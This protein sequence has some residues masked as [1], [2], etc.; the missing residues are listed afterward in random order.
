MELRRM[1]AAD[2]FERPPLAPKGDQHLSTCTRLLAELGLRQS[3]ER[4][5]PSE[6]LSGG[7]LDQQVL[8]VEVGSIAQGSKLTMG[9]GIWQ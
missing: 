1:R 9:D 4:K 8:V 5:H 6:G 3:M 7:L 2:L